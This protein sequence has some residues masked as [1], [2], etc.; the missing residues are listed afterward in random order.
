[1]TSEDLI[2]KSKHDLET[3]LAL[4][5]SGTEAAIR[6]LPQLL[7]WLQDINWP[8]AAPLADLL[9]EVG[10]PLIPHLRSILSSDDDMWIYWVLQ[11][12]VAH[13][14][15]ALQQQLEP[16][17]QALVHQGERAENDIIALGLLAGMPSTGVELLRLRV[18]RRRQA[19][20]DMADELAD[21][22]RQLPTASDH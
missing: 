14:P 10:E 8:V 13:L 9:V 1:M 17:L 16:E 15:T 19:L 20:L 21:I 18:R 3:V 22:E 11:F 2:P 6:I 7:T 5:H 4:K 12:V